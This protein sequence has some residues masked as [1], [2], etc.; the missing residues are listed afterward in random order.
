MLHANTHYALES[1]W[2]YVQEAAWSP[3]EV[4]HATLSITH[5]E[6]VSL[7]P[8]E[9]FTFFSDDQLTAEVIRA[10]QLYCAVKR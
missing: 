5:S 1:K 8:S 2:I 4:L 7:F 6:A 3:D 10:D 9:W